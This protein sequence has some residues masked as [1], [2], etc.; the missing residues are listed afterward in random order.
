MS[1]SI[2]TQC[3]GSSRLRRLVARPWRAVESQYLVSTRRL[4]DSDAEQH[5][6]E[7]MLEGVKPPLPK[8]RALH[9]LLFTPF[10][11]PPLRHGSRFGARH[12][13]GLW[14]GGEEQRTV[15]AEVAYYRLLFLEATAATLSP[16]SLELSA[17]QAS[18]RTERA[19]DLTRPPFDTYQEAIS[20]P[21]AYAES[22]ALGVAMREAGVLAFRYVSARDLKK[23]ACLALFSAKAFAKTQPTPPQAWHCVATK[24]RVEVQKKDVFGRLSFSFPRTDFAVD[25]RLPRPAL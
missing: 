5:L 3:A 14:Y 7:E 15:F 1:S 17:F 18:V 13:R 11:Y 21:T 20:S 24:E 9:Y 4:V 12:E 8:A 25:G 6:L 19:V 10:R 22:Q 16:L 23:G 2:W